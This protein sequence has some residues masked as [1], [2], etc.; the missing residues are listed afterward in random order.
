MCIILAIHMLIIFWLRLENVQ[1]SVI[2]VLIEFYDKAIKNWQNND[3]VFTILVLKK[4]QV[5]DV[6]I[7]YYRTKSEINI[8]FSSFLLKIIKI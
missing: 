1:Y 6:K 7:N 4:I 8:F 2:V 5:D 3:Y